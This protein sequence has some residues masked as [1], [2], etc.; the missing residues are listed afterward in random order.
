MLKESIMNCMK[1][2]E[3]KQCE[4]AEIL[5]TTPGNVSNKFNRNAFTYGEILS[6]SLFLN[7]SV[8]ELLDIKNRSA[9]QIEAIS[10]NLKVNSKL[11]FPEILATTVNYKLISELLEELGGTFLVEESY[12]YQYNTCIDITILE[13]LKSSKIT[14]NELNRTSPQILIAFKVHEYLLNKTEEV[15]YNEQGTD[16]ISR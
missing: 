16:N 6:I 10:K 11:L 1:K 12:R 13:K 2:K 5:H 14:L 7:I 4:L 15:K 9:E 8:Y 3:H